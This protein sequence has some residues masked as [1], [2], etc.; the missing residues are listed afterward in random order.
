MVDITSLTSLNGNKGSF[1]G[2]IAEFGQKANDYDNEET[3]VHIEKVSPKILLKNLYI[4]KQSAK[5]L[6]KDL[7]QIWAIVGK[8]SI[9]KID[10]RIGEVI[11]FDAVVVDVETDFYLNTS[12][13]IYLKSLSKIKTRAKGNGQKFTDFWAGINRN[14]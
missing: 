10:P 7:D 6:V 14:K 2:C 8:K 13:D 9:T 4:K 12:S 3:D 11:S 5:I 1:E